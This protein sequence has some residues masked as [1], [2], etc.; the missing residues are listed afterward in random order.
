MRCT[1]CGD[2][3][4]FIVNDLPESVGCFGH[5]GLVIE[6]QMRTDDYHQVTVEKVTA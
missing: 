1:H 4:M 2:E 3:G 5:I 6:E